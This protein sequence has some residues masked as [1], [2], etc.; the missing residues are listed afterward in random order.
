MDILSDT[1]GLLRTRGQL[2]GRLEFTAPWAFLFPGGKGICLMVS[3]GSCLLGV[4]EQPPLVRLSE[5]DFVFLAHPESYS[6]RSS[7]EIR[8][9][10]MEALV[11][12]ERFRQTRLIRFGAEQPG[13]RTSLIA[14]CFTFATPESAWLAQ[15]LPPVLRLSA[16]EARAPEWF[17]STIQLIHSEITEELPGSSAII[18]RLADVLFVQAVRTQI[19][20]AHKEARPGWL[21]ALADPQLASALWL[22]HTQ[23][24][25]AW[26]VS[27]LAREVAMS[28]SAF[29]G[30][31]REVVGSTPM[32]HLTTWRMVRAAGMLQDNPR[33]K[34]AA[35]AATVGYES[36]AAFGKVFKRSLGVSPGRYR[37][38]LDGWLSGGAPAAR[39]D[40]SE[41]RQ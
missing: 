7:P 27:E 41:P 15:A 14:G 28:R 10:P 17:Q 23:P 20:T 29:A 40:S 6:L 31:F 35:I 22:M 24:G 18:D 33:M 32:E 37:R 21:R 5:G 16:S 3:R 13:A 12:P 11:P 2:Y 34:V 8:P 39:G 9:R 36:E 26:T 19:S 1:A 4:D 38:P 25:R 30:R